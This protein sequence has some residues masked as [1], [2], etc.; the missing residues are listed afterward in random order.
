M[1]DLE[2][3]AGRPSV[4]SIGKTHQ[5]C[6]DRALHRLDS[7]GWHTHAVCERH[8]SWDAFVGASGL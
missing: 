3:A 7:L 4:Y 6:H 5:V 1:T 8:E 2:L